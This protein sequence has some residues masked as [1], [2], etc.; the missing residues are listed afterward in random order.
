MH[1]SNLLGVSS[2]D[3]PPA[4]GDLCVSM[5]WSEGSA[6]CFRMGLNI[7]FQVVLL[8]GLFGLVNLLPAM[9]PSLPFSS[10]NMA[11]EDICGFQCLW[12]DF[13]FIFDFPLYRLHPRV[14]P[15]CLIYNSRYLS[16]IPA[17]H[18]YPPPSFPL[19][20]YNKMRISPL[21]GSLP[22]PFLINTTLHSFLG[23][24][25]FNLLCISYCV[26]RFEIIY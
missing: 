9:S 20:S 17:Y 2:Q 7:A 15:S 14:H 11:L 12:T 24:G 26:S 4:S 19:A 16:N 22:F 18:Y 1:I 23:L 21:I 5:F 6:K 8:P 25:I 3:S 10:R 13:I